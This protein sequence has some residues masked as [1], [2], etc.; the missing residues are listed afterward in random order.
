MLKTNTYNGSKNASVTLTTQSGSSGKPRFEPGPTSNSVDLGSSSFKWKDLYLAGNLTDGTNSISV[1]SIVAGVSP[2]NMVTTDTAQTITGTKTF[3]SGTSGGIKFSNN[4]G[5]LNHNS[6]GFTLIPYNNYW[7]RYYFSRED[8][9]YSIASFYPANNVGLTND[10]GKTANPWSNLYL[11]NSIDIT[12]ASSGYSETKTTIN[13]AQ[14]K[15]SATPTGGSA[16]YVELLPTGNKGLHIHD[17][18]GT[19]SDTYYQ[20]DYIQAGSAI[21]NLPTTSGTLALTSQIPTNVV[22]TTNAQTISGYKTFTNNSGIKLE[23][24]NNGDI[25]TAALSLG[26]IQGGL[27]GLLINVRDG[28]GSTGF[29]GSLGI[30][31]EQETANGGLMLLPVTTGTVKDIGRQ[32]VPWRNLYLSGTLNDPDGYSVSVADLALLVSYAKNQGWIQ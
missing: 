13:N 11:S 30:F 21:V 3:G 17:A 8:D 27:K 16:S 23:N 2:S 28:I 20:A 15:T 18:S 9:S 10:I 32:S 26:Q 25:N 24:S 6:G 31:P 1:A 5:F 19:N 29:T 12:K 22:N 14:I 4:T 7:A